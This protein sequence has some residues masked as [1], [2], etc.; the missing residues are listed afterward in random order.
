ML[1]TG[2]RLAGYP[3]FVSDLLWPDPGVPGRQILGGP[4]RTADLKQG[5]RK[6]EDPPPKADARCRTSGRREA[7]SPPLLDEVE[8]PGT[9]P[10]RKDTARD[11]AR[12]APKRFRQLPHATIPKSAADVNEWPGSRL[13]SRNANRQQRGVCERQHR[14]PGSHRLEGWLVFVSQD[15]WQDLQRQRQRHQGK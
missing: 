14:C 6:R 11:S 9:T 3:P 1:W 10:I 13:S 7:D 5:D 2:H 4:M 8:R 15:D 12:S